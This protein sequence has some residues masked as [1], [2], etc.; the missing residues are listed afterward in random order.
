[1]FPKE[2]EPGFVAVSE[3]FVAEDEEGQVLGCVADLYTAKVVYLAETNVP[4]EIL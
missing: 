2:A 3:A 4:S 1:M